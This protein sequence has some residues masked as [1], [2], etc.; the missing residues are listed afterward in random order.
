[1]VRRS[2]RK[3]AILYL[4]DPF[5][6]THSW[7]GSQQLHLIQQLAM[8]YRYQCIGQSQHLLKLLCLLC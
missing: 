8:N 5:I 4:S 1:M 3:L 6:S 2:T 7:C